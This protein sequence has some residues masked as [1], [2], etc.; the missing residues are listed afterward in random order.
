MPQSL[1]LPLTILFFY[2]RLIMMT[3]IPLDLSKCH[4]QTT[5]TLLVA[6]SHISNPFRRFPLALRSSLTPD[7]I[8]RLG[9]YQLYQNSRWAD[10]GRNVLIPWKSS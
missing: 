7:V 3:K 2:Y 1:L 10:L 9:A 6:L 5:L 4:R 8:R